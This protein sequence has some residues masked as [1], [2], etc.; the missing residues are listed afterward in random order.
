[1][2]DSTDKGI[3]PSL[4][5]LYELAERAFHIRRSPT[6]LAR[7]LNE[8]G[9]TINNW[10]KDRGV[11]KQG[12]LKAQELYGWSASWI[13]E[14]IEPRLVG[15]EE[16]LRPGT[17]QSKR[18]EVIGEITSNAAGE[19]VLSQ[20]AGEGSPRKLLAI[21][22]GLPAQGFLVS[23]DILQ[24]RYRAGEFLVIANE[25][26]PD[27]GN[28]AVVLMHDGHWYIKVLSWRRGGM[29]QLTG[30]GGAD[31]HR[32]LT[33]READIRSMRAILSHCG[34]QAIQPHP[35]APE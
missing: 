20:M 13:R 7:L 31:D 28:D 14:G 26:E 9:Q 34:M 19:V 5:R 12:A 23:T 3:H 25:L 27:A 33:L 24:P 30:L 8:S 21:T 29:V 32:L 1:M 11:S 16:V 4:A 35:D 17:I 15:A 2:E 6:E 10:A 22:G 18:I